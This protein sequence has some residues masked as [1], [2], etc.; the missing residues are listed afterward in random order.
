VQQHGDHITVESEVGQSTTFRR[1][2]PA[3]ELE[4]VPE[5]VEKKIPY[6]VGGTE[7][8]LLVEDEEAVRELEETRTPTT[9]LSKKWIPL[10]ITL[11]I[12][13]VLE[14]GISIS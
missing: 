1:Y 11:R 7:T 12:R 9:E 4:I 8:I 14:D 6:P 10:T 5:Y 13:E 2:F 3:L